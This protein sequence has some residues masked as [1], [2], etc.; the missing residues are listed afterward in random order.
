MKQHTEKVWQSENDRR[1][2]NKEA[3][4][5]Y[6]H[7]SKKLS[8][9]MSV[10]GLSQAD[11][12]NK[13][14][15]NGY[16]IAQSALSK[17]L[18]Y[19]KTNDPSKDSKHSESSGSEAPYSITLA[20][21]L[22]ICKALEVN[23][24]EI[25]DANSAFDIEDAPTRAAKRVPIILDPSED[26]FNGYFG[27]YHCYFFSTISSE[28]KL[29]H[30]TLDFKPSPMNNYC[31]AIFKLD[32]NKLGSDG[33]KIY[34]EYSG[35]LAISPRMSSCYCL[36]ENPKIGELCFVV[37]RHMYLNN[38]SLKCR[39]AVVATASA[40]DNRRPTIHRMLISSRVVPDEKVDILKAQLLLNSSDILISAANLENLRGQESPPFPEQVAALFD[41]TI[42]KEEYYK[43]SEFQIRGV[44]IPLQDRL[45]TIC[46]LR[47]AS[48]APKYNKVGSKA[49]ELTFNYLT[50]LFD[51]SLEESIK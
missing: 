16:P 44:D 18:S 2:R 10:K 39:L 30:G 7:I 36:L 17:I 51:S 27:R 43:L 37:F 46:I 49:D 35:K 13:C 6:E 4:S 19:P 32:T 24:S 22:H 14:K 50:E 41:A 5:L 15:E 25:L 12:L 1:I 9:I 23:P 26:E 38:E 8:K 42:R 48:I 40:G 21:F 29:L 47:N 45:R 20:N 31:S 3:R 28:T 33:S 34:K 11:I